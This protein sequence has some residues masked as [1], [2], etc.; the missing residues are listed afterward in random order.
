MHESGARNL[1]NVERFLIVPPLAATFGSAPV[2]V[3]DISSKG[4]RFRHEIP[5]E[6]GAK[7]TLKFAE[8]HLMPLILEAVIVWTQQEPDGRYVS[9]VRTYGA[10]ASIDALMAQLHASNRSNRIEELRS[11]DRFVVQPMIDA[12]FGAMPAKLRDISA[13]GARIEHDETVAGDQTAMLAFSLPGSSVRVEVMGRVVW[14]AV[15]SLDRASSHYH[16]GVFIRDK[17]ELMRLA[18]GQLSET[19][20]AVLDT[21]SLRLKLRILKARAREL[22]P[23]YREI[24]TGGIPAEQ[25]LLIQ[26][27]REELRLNPEEAQHW[28]RRARIVINDPATRAL[29]PMIADHPDALAVWEYLDRSV[30]PGIISRAFSMT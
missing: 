7:A 22:A 20:R 19:A 8:P 5:L 21:S 2:A 6:T 24:D 14:S 12:M 9:G 25:Y 10:P 30:D 13:R 15:K 11:S 29:A 16:S 4:G 18:I 3:S 1:R 28:Y 23:S 27:V 17:P 26:G